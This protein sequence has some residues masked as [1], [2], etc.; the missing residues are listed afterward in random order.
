M[1]GDPYYKLFNLPKD[2][3]EKEI[4]KRY[5]E[6]AKKLHPDQNKEKDA[7]Q[8][9]QELQVA[10]EYLI[11]RA[12]SPL[13]ATIRDHSQRQ[14][15]RTAENEWI[16]YKKRAYEKYQ[17]K[18][19]KQKEELEKWYSLLNSGWRIRVLYSVSFLAFILF[20]FLLSDNFA[21]TESKEITIEKFSNVK[22]KSMN[23]HT[24]SVAVDNNEQ[25]YWLNNFNTN[26]FTGLPKTV[27]ER[28]SIFHHPKKLVV[29]TTSEIQHIPVHFTF[30]WA[31]NVLYVLFLVPILT[32]F[33]RKNDTWKIMIYY[34]SVYGV[35]GFMLFFLLTEN[36]W[37]HLF[38][39]GNL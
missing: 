11:A 5:K 30:Y 19:Q 26:H 2:C 24:V 16:L 35:G 13:Q 18:K 21:E 23:N 9:F 38:T 37:L 17:A 3:S 29:T 20:V 31:Q 22:Y 14:H 7:V 25:E 15:E 36:R 1:H 4:R 10:Y 27:I 39:L 34:L 28:T 6:L 33:Y 12:N 8:K 32:C